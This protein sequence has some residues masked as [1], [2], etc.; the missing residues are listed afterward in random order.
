MSTKTRRALVLGGTGAVGSEVLRA[1][2]RAG[3]PTTFT[4]HAAKEKAQALAT[5]LDQRA[6]PLD[7]L[8][9]KGLSQLAAALEAEG[10]TPDVLV[11]CAA[12]LRGG[13]I[14]GASDEDWDATMNVNGRSAFVACREFGRQMAARGGGDIVL[15]GAL[16]RSQSLPVPPLFAASQGL[17]A[18]LAMAVAKDLGPQGVRVNVVA[19]GL[20]DSGLSLGLDPKLRADYQSF[21]ALRRL[22]SPAEAA[23][24]IAWL[25]L[26]NSYINGKVVSVNGGI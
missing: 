17:L 20:L 7:L 13:P 1:L 6:R 18:A 4:Y 11:H 14:D 23:K 21:S 24:T 16:D 10:E 15:T 2:A 8:D 22:G 5:E 12:V 25:A 3:V 9:S 19:L 26:S